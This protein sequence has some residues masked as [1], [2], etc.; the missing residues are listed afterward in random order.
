MKARPMEGVISDRW[1]SIL[2]GVGN[3]PP[4]VR[5]GAARQS[6]GYFLHPNYDAEAVC[7]PSCQR[8]GGAPKY[9]P[10]VA[11]ERMRRK[12]ERRVA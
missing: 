1:R 3:P 12:L 2:H 7:L 10:I 9:P 11:G 6:L 5:S 8:P 4:T